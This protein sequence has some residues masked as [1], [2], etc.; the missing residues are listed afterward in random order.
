ME[1]G[2]DGDPNRALVEAVDEPKPGIYQWP[3]D[4]RRLVPVD[5]E[6]SQTSDAR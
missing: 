6:Q 3:A 4:L 2:V 1:I 5:D